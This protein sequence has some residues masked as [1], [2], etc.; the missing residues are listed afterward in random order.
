L[1]KKKEDPPAKA[2]EAPAKE[3]G[4]KGEEWDHRASTDAAR[5]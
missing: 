4:S 2:K 3:E 1:H 5:T